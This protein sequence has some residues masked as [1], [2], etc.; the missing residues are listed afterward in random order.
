MSVG[1]L[2]Q[3]DIEVRELPKAGDKVSL[4]G[5]DLIF[6]EWDPSENYTTSY[7]VRIGRTVGECA[8]NLAAAINCLDN[9][10]GGYHLNRLLTPVYAMQY[11]KFAHLAMRNL[12]SDGS[13]VEVTVASEGRLVVFE[14]GTEDT[15][16]ETKP[17]P[18]PA[19]TIKAGSVNVTYGDSYVDSNGVLTVNVP[20]TITGFIDGDTASSLA[21][22]LVATVKNNGTTVTGGKPDSGTY[23]LSLSGY[24]SSKYDIIFEDGTLTVAKKALTVTAP[25][26]KVSY[27]DAV[28]SLTPTITGTVSGDT[29]TASTSTTY[30][31]KSSVGS[32]PVTVGEVTGAS[33]Y[34][35]T[36]VDG[37]ITVSKKALTVTLPAYELT[38]GTAVPDVDSATS[39]SVVSGLVDGD[40]IQIS[41]YTSY[42]STSSAGSVHTVYDSTIRINNSMHYPNYSVKVVN[43][44]ITVLKKA[45]T[46]TVDNKSTDK[47]VEPTF[48]CTGSGFVNN[49]TLA[50][51]GG[52][53]V[54]SISDGTNTYNSVEGLDAG[55]Y[56]VSVSGYSSSNYDI[57]CVSGTLTI[58]SA[59][60]ALT[61][62]ADNK[63]WA[64]GGG[65]RPTFTCTG[66]GFEEGDSLSSLSGE[67]VYKFYNYET[68][69][70]Y[71]LGDEVP[72]Y[73]DIGGPSGNNTKL[74]IKVSGFSSDKYDITYQDGILSLYY[75]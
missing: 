28:P 70:E 24:S 63:G 64:E 47:G 3:W 67:A 45:L 5:V 46:I 75:I 15:S 27:G 7:N 26:P 42:T 35:V 17:A 40:T 10:F 13:G 48:T 16:A 2:P 12:A 49:Q 53:P 68:G 31:Q 1:T 39:N 23:S 9:K 44:K 37:A 72:P 59:K 29:V 66:T 30:A 22:T 36:K 57:Q 20:V 73:S 43:G 55:E 61:I 4:C 33:N 6:G 8:C 52:T 32:Y 14:Q 21:G 18:K 51:L 50:N 11:G 56:T 19:L 58:N 54:Y 38:Y 60:I 71:E 34:E 74:T 69:E 25:S 62:K 65:P 41:I